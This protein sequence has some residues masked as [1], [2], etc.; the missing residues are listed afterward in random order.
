MISFFP[1]YDWCKYIERLDKTEMYLHLRTGLQYLQWQF[2][3]GANKPWLLKYPAN[4][5]NESYISR[6]FPGVKYVVT[7]R[8]PFPVMASLAK[9]ISQTH[10]LNCKTRDSK[11]FSIWA[12]EEFVS[13][14]DR[15]LA[16]RDPE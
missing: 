2:H 6:T 15:H 13:E 9:M 16:W 1:A 3:Q 7:H 11:R 5:G 8:D 12:F 10:L 4:L 14:M